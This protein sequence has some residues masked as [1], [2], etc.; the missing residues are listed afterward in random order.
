L[1]EASAGL[2]FQWPPVKTQ[3]FERAVH[4]TGADEFVGQ[5]FCPQRFSSLAVMRCAEYQKLFNCGIS[6]PNAASAEEIACVER[7]RTLTV[8]GHEKTA[9]VD[10][11]EIEPRKCISCGAEDAGRETDFCRICATRRGWEQKKL[12]VRAAKV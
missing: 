7:E 9:D 8:D 1:D 4:V 6:C 12:D 2:P 10:G 3:F 11:S 5:I